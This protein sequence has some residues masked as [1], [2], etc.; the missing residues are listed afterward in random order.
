MGAKTSDFSIFPK[1][2]NED[3]GGD[4]GEARP[5]AGCLLA[6]G[7][8]HPTSRSSKRA[9][10]ARIVCLI[11]GARR[12]DSIVRSPICRRRLARNDRRR[13]AAWGRGRRSSAGRSGQDERLVRQRVLQSGGPRGHV[14]LV[15]IDG[16]RLLIIGKR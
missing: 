7:L 13:S 14:G 8:W 3:S 15:R 4:E 16:Q 12:G 9:A 2:L 5:A 1:G 11:I 6:G 10:P